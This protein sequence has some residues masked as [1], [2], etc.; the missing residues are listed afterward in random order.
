MS[1]FASEPET[2]TSPLP[3]VYGPIESELA[4]VERILKTELRSDHP[5]VDELVRY[6]CLL[7]GKRLRPT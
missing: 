7:G 2:A 4:E 5:Y 1:R 6:G 3:D